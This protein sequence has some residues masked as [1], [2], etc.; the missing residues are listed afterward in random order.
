M[1]QYFKIDHQAAFQID[2]L[3]WS[4]DAEDKNGCIGLG[5]IRGAEPPMVPWNRVLVTGVPQ[6]CGRATE[7]KVCK[8]KVRNYTIFCLL[9]LASFM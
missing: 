7:V 2:Y 1:H 6:I 3:E 9:C 5:S 8:G 4:K